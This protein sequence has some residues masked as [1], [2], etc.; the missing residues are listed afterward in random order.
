MGRVRKGGISHTADVKEGV[1]AG[2]LQGKDR[3]NAKAL[4]KDAPVC[5]KNSR[6]ASVTTGG[7]RG[8]RGGEFRMTGMILRTLQAIAR[9]LDFMK[10]E[11]LWKGFK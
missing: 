7:G 9:H 6:N 5:S 11:K 2:L 3:L 4:R 8:E 10:W 1:E